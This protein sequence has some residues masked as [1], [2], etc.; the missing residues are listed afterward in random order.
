VEGLRA[1][2]A[3]TSA[4]EVSALQPG[5]RHPNAGAVKTFSAPS[6]AHAIRFSAAAP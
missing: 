5:R 2:P 6:L 4:A 1:R 3:R